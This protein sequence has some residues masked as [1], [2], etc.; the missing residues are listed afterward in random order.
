MQNVFKPG[1]KFTQPVI[2]KDKLLKETQT[3]ILS[4][5]SEKMHQ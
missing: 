4:L 5:L 2:T 1:R 3:V